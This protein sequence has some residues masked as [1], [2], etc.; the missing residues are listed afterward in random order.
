VVDLTRRDAAQAAEEI[1]KALGRQ[2]RLSDH[3]VDA[4][5]A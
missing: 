3:A 2:P 5:P 1:L 4:S